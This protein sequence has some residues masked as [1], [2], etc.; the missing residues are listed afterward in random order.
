MP[1]HWNCFVAGCTSNFSSK[2]KDL[3]YYRV[4]KTLKKQY[5]AFFKTDCVNWKNAVICSLHWSKKRRNSKDMPDI[6]VPGTREKP[7]R[8]LRCSKRGKMTN[9]HQ[10]KAKLQLQKAE[11]QQKHGIFRRNKGS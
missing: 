2:T 6:R 3:K 1:K 10:K 5:D 4:P 9:T 7:K 11:L 8:N